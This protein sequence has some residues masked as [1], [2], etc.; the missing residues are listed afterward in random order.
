M[1]QQHYCYILKNDRGQTYVGYTVNPKKR[2]R[3]HNGEIVGGA[4]YTKG[5]GPWDFLF[6]ITSPDLDVHT[7]LSLEWWLKHPTGSRRNKPKEYCG[8]GGRILTLPLVLCNPKFEHMLFTLHVCSEYKKDVEEMC[9]NLDSVSIHD[10][11]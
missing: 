9:Q 10:I 6:F 1:A 7:G 11:T 8:I 2:L 3:Q 4:R 5:K